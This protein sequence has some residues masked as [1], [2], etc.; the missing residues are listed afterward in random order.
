MQDQF[1]NFERQMEEETRL[2]RAAEDARMSSA[3]FVINFHLYFYVLRETLVKLE[4]TL[5]AEIKRRIEANKALQEM[6]EA[7]II[8]M[9]EKLESGFDE[10]LE[11]VE[12]A[13]SAVSDRL[14]LIERDF[15][16]ERDR[17]VRDIEDKNALVARDVNTL[18]QAFEN[19]RVLRAEKEAII[20][21][22]LTDLETKT[23]DKLETHK[24][25]TDSKLIGVRADMEEIHRINSTGED[26][27]ENFVLEELASLKNSVIIET[28][29]RE[30]ADDDLVNALNHY[31]KALQD[32]LRIINTV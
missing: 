24:I 13:V 32:A 31:T 21:K 29:S 6:F 1:L 18:Q 28:Q 20:I 14:A 12:E 15:S 17:Y 8:N 9:Q 26:K 7:Q 4:K 10:R 16:I 27:F 19:E 25:S 30:S 23:D 22:R 5:N 3:R 2:K 11:K